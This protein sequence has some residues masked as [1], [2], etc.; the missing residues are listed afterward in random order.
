MLAACAAP[1]Q[2]DSQAIRGIP[3]TTKQWLAELPEGEFAIGI[4]YADPNLE[5]TSGAI[6]KDYAAVAMSR[7]HASYVVD[8][9]IFLDLANA[10]ELD[11][12]RL[13]FNVVVSA[14]LEF[15]RH[16]SNNLQ[17]VDSFVSAG[18][19]IG[20]YGI[21]KPV[22]ISE[23]SVELNEIP[24][25]W[26]NREGVSLMDKQLNSVASSHQARLGDALNMAQEKALRQ[27]A[28]YRLQ[29]VLGKIRS[30]NDRTDQAIALE[31]VT[32][33]QECYF[34]RINIYQWKSGESFSY[35]VYVQMGAKP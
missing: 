34:Q 7:N 2:I 21:N 3:F 5:A 11:L 19:F 17:L 30:I 9:E 24:P 27:I 8:K 26:Y 12:N 6:A 22:T 33:N 23:S 18:Y 14:D 29:N 15:L 28:Q 35:T 4:S 16:C 1:P 10:P 31:T 20:L 13:S 25:A 32:R